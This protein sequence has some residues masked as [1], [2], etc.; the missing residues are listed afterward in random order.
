MAWAALAQLPAAE[1]RPNVLE[2]ELQRISK[3]AGPDT[4]PVY[5]GITNVLPKY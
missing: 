1:T 3:A 5:E 2:R 4:M